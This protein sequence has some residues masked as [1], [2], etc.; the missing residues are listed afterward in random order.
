MKTITLRYEGGEISV[1]YDGVVLKARLSP[2]SNV[3]KGDEIVVAGRAVVVQSVEHGE[4]EGGGVS[5]SS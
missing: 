4:G 1:P 3:C 2:A 5:G